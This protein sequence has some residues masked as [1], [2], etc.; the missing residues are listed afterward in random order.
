M[1][2]TFIYST[3]KDR[4][5]RELFGISLFTFY[6]PLQVRSTHVYVIVATERKTDWVREREKG[7][8]GGKNIIRGGGGTSTVSSGTV[9]LLGN[10]IDH[11]KTC[12]F[13]FSGNMILNTVLI[14]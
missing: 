4:P 10:E 1:N 13:L 2:F 6:D 14:I 9:G 3:L 11:S 12:L 8:Y 7:I 5:L